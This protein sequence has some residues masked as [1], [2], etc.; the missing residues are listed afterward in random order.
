M[1][2]T[3]LISAIVVSYNTRSMTIECLEKLCIALEGIDS[4]IIVVDNASSDGSPEAIRAAFPSVIL[5]AR[6]TNSGFGTANNQAMRLANGPFF[7]LLNS[8]AFP[9]PAAIS[10]LLDFIRAHPR[11]G[12]VGPRLV[13]PDGSLQISC[14]PF[15]TPLFAWLENLGIA[16]GYR[17][18]PHDSVRR[19]DFLIGACM[20]VRRE[21]YEE[22]GGF[23]EAFFMYS[24]EADWQRRMKDAG[25]ESVFVPGARVTHVGG[26]SGAREEAGVSR[27]FFASLDY[28]ERKH[29][30]LAGLVAFRLAM[31][32]GCGLRAL[33]WSAVSLHP[34]RRPLALAKARKHSR[35]WLRQAFQW[36]RA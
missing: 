35:L 1:K 14:H 3:P 5:V 6:D 4:E 10:T 16:R 32:V 2:S 22:V 13:N 15:P 12:V 7:L 21:A 19:V 25:W 36:S 24:E 11:G 29:H 34:A 9:E 28:Y 27:H 30:G 23:D 31:T 20:L 18:W 8:D 33:L 17:N 26:A